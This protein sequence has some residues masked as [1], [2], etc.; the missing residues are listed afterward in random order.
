MRR[1]TPLFFI[2]VLYG[3]ELLDELIYGLQG[4]V[5]PDLKS[6]L[7]LTYTEVGLLFTVPGLFGI[8]ADPIIGLIGDTRFRR[9]LVV[10]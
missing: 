6:D 7:A 1:Y 10:G 3:V 2:A 9:A 8:F 5:L 4:A